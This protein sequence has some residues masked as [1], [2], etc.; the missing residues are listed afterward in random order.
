[1][2][3]AAAVRNRKTGLCELTVNNRLARPKR[4]EVGVIALPRELERGVC[5]NYCIVSSLCGALER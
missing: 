4:L 5:E 3:A 2:T 1:M